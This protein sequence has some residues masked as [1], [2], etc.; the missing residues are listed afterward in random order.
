MAFTKPSFERGAGGQKVSIGKMPKSSFRWAVHFNKNRK[1]L[2]EFFLDSFGHYVIWVN[3]E[4]TT[5][6]ISDFFCGTGPERSVFQIFPDNFR[7]LF[8]YFIFFCLF[9]LN[10]FWIIIENIFHNSIA[11]FLN[12][13]DFF[14]SVRRSSGSCL[15]IWILVKKVISLVSLGWVSHL[16]GYFTTFLLGA[17]IPGPKIRNVRLYYNVPN[18]S[19]LTNTC[20]GWTMSNV[21]LTP[22]FWISTSKHNF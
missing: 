1:V 20:A 17:L 8:E 11:N 10:I 3:G 15:W 21:H 6:R 4:W 12:F 22:L 19:L 9:Y 13:P 16:K 7:I 14:C 18:R 5:V 2:S